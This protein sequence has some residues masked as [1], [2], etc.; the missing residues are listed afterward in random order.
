[1]KEDGNPVDY[2]IGHSYLRY[3]H[4]ISNCEQLYEQKKY[5]VKDQPLF[6]DSLRIGV[7]RAEGEIKASK[8]ILN[9]GDSLEVKCTVS[10]TH[11]LQ[12]HVEYMEDRVQKRVLFE[13]IADDAQKQGSCDRKQTFSRPSLPDQ[14]TFTATIPALQLNDSASFSCSWTSV[15]RTIA[16]K[17]VHVFVLGTLFLCF[18]NGKRGTLAII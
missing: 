11:F 9:V 2:Y 6:S 8:E 18:F 15:G 14:S 7:V 13:N 1:M 17:E 10:G 3:V 5:R 4:S 12:M 16:T